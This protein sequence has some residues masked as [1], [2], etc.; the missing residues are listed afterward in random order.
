MGASL[1][2]E[3]LTV[4]SEIFVGFLLGEAGH[5]PS[6]AATRS[7][8]L[9][10]AS[11]REGAWFMQGNWGWQDAVTKALLCPARSNP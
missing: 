10:S 7:V 11:S 3:V 9:T 5:H 4:T 1:T 2:Q 8:C 6:S